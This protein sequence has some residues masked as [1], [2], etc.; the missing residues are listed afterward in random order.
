MPRSFPP[1]QNPHGW[2]GAEA[3]RRAIL[4]KPFFYRPPARKGKKKRTSGY[5]LPYPAPAR[6]DLLQSFNS[7]RDKKNT[8]TQVGP[9]AHSAPFLGIKKKAENTLIQNFLTYS[10]KKIYTRCE[11][12]N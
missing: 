6:R 3:K 1:P 7:N 10:Q 4:V 8:H 12:Q 5:F 11:N 2:I 9:L